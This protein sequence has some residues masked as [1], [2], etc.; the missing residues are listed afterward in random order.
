M[1]SYGFRL[2][3]EESKG[4][5]LSLDSQVPCACGV[6]SLGNQIQQTMYKCNNHD[7]ALSS[8]ATNNNLFHTTTD[9]TKIHD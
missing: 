5:L 2:L 4:G 8:E 3:A 1:S 7:R 6:D 9:C